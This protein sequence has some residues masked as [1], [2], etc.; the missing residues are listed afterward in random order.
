MSK[1]AFLDAAKRFIFFPSISELNEFF[2]NR[3]IAENAENQ[4]LVA[5]KAIIDERSGW[6][7]RTESRW[8]QTNPRWPSDKP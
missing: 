8:W 6:H 7:V 5:P 1:E 2:L 4:L 3:S